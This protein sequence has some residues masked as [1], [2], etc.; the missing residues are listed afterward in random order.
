MDQFREYLALA[1]DY[2]LEGQDAIAFAEKRVAEEKEK[3]EREERRMK[4]DAEREK[5]WVEREEKK[6]WKKRKKKDNSN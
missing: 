1:K 6:N 3:I 2:D 4:Y 5:P